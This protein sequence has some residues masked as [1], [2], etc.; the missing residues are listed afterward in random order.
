LL[1][2]AVRDGKWDSYEKKEIR[3]KILPPM[4]KLKGQILGLIGFGRI[5]QRL[6]PKAKGFELR[7]IAFDPY[8]SSSAFETLGVESVS[9]D[10]LL[11]SS[12]YVSVHAAFTP[13]AWHMIGIDQFKMMKHTAYIINCARGEFIDEQA[14]Y[15]ALTQG[16]IAGA[17]LDVLERE[18]VGLD[19]PLLRLENVI[20]TAHSAYYSE[21]SVLKYRQRPYE[22]IARIIKGQQPR[23]LLNPEVKGRFEAAT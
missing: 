20:I 21:Q 11:K 14:L 8:V 2:K 6:V 12:D 10:Y 13:K 15:L 19:H 5:P 16:Y 17:A 22:E 18:S 7:I 23:R 9:F 3:L 4:F 1:D